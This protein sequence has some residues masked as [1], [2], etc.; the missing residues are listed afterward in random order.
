MR[1]L[2][3]TLTQLHRVVHRISGGRVGRHFPGGV[4]VVWLTLPGRTSGVLRT[5]PLLGVRRDD[6]SWV[7]AGS[8]GGDSVEPAWSLNARAAAARGTPCRLEY[9]GDSW[10]VRVTVL[11][12]EAERA[13]A[14]ALL[15]GRWRFFRAY[16]ARAGREI[17]VFVLTPTLEN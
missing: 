16:A 2:L 17:P 4:P 13:R 5:S 3:R 7:V 12:Q 11:E 1:R 6:G 9:A 8:A 14:Y 10:P 15:V